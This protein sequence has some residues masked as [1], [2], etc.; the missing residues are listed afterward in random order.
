MNILSGFGRMPLRRTVTTGPMT[1]KRFQHLD[2]IIVS[3]I[4]PSGKVYE[5]A[6]DTRSFRTAQNNAVNMGYYARTVSTSPQNPLWKPV[7]LT[8]PHGTKLVGYAAIIATYGLRVKRPRTLYSLGDLEAS[9][10]P[11]LPESWVVMKNVTSNGYTIDDHLLFAACYEPLSME[12]IEAALSEYNSYSSSFLTSLTLLVKKH[13]EEVG[14]R[15]MWFAAEVLFGHKL[16]V[17]DLPPTTT[18]Q[19]LLDPETFYSYCREH[20]TVTSRHRIVNNLLGSPSCCPLVYKSA[21]LKGAPKSAIFAERM[22]TISTSMHNYKDLFPRA[23]KYLYKLETR[24]S[25]EIENIYPDSENIKPFLAALQS[26]SALKDEDISEDMLR[27]VHQAVLGPNYQ[28]IFEHHKGNLYRCNQAWLE[29]TFTEQ[30]GRVEFIP[31][32]APPPEELNTMMAEWISSLNIACKAE[33]DPVVLAAT[34]AFSFI[35]AHP[36][37]DG[38]GRLHRFILHWVLFK[39][40]IC[41]DLLVP[42]SAHLLANRSDY[43]YVLQQCG[44]GITSACLYVK[45]GA[46]TVSP[47]QRHLWRSFD[48]TPFVEYMFSVLNTLTQE[49]LPSQLNFLKKYDECIASAVALGADPKRIHTYARTFFKWRFLSWNLVSPLSKYVMFPEMSQEAFQ[50]LCKLA[51]GEHRHS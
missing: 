46:V 47:G 2:T 19:P 44:G 8:P 35:W 38:N 31:F 13:S 5:I 37:G 25:L 41:P 40:G 21:A 29:S 7:W 42:V 33:I 16:D 3:M 36:M 15:R 50:Y 20:P 39:L 49:N 34:W 48:A 24:S 32:I 27:R 28:T 26:L 4:S 9:Q 30:D 17:N 11:G 12:V 22:R 6:M 18:E 45:N 14:V 10:L 23:V 51:R 43:Q 1:L